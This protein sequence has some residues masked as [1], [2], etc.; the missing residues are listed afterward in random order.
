M[1]ETKDISTQNPQ[2]TQTQ[3]NYFDNL[4]SSETS[5]QETLKTKE[6]LLNQLNEEQGIHFNDIIEQIETYTKEGEFGSN[7]I[8][9]T[10]K[11][12]TG[13]SYLSSKIVK[14]FQDNPLD[15]KNKRVQC[16]ALT[17]Q[18]VKELGKKLISSDVKINGLNGVST[19]HSYFR[20]KPVIN[21]KT[22]KEEYVVEDDEKI[23]KC[24]ILLIDEV[25]ML[26]GELW[27]LITSK[28]YL[29][30]TIIL[31][32]DEYQVPPVNNSE[33]NLFQNPNITKFKLE[34]IVRQA[35]GNPIIQL[36]SEI[37][38]KIENKD[39]SN[40]SFCIRR[41]IDYSKKHNEIKFVED[42]KE[43]LQEYYDYVK[44]DI[45]KP[46]LNSRFYDSFMT[47]YTNAAVDSFNHIAKC[48]FKQSNTVNL[49]DKG[50]LLI[51]QE[52]AFDPYIDNCLMMNN[53]SEFYVEKLEEEIYKG[54]PIYVAYNKDNFI[55]IIKPE[56]KLK[57]SNEIKKL[58][59]AARIDRK[60]WIKF[61]SFKK[62]FVEVKQCFAC[63]THKSQGST[64]G[65]V[66][67]DLHNLPWSTDIDLAFRLC[68]VAIT[69]TSDMLVAKN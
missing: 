31:I 48:I 46:I 57:Y 52:P 54:I 56:G 23:K 5:A 14:Y 1:T 55:R 53:G 58:A 67:F 42:S 45:G 6:S 60:L 39:Y 15:R 41:I 59:N 27:N 25:S 66:F 24:S 49:V 34:N 20:I 21:F 51:L 19:V 26:D 18:A 38:E 69:R 4:N 22:G 40:Q 11:A 9:I 7:T 28:S 61:Y 50:D 3:D 17:H 63:T 8:L 47:T 12:G 16:T 35:E 30:G 68:Y 64:V 33:F 29:Y 44:E 13:K 36:A 43:F 65:R 37:V 32:G 62:K 2:N 10:G